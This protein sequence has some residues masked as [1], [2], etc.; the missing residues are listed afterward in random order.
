M[1]TKELR[2]DVLAKNIREETR[3]SV[4]GLRSRGIL[5]RLAAV[6]TDSN[7]AILSYAESK[8][9]MA[10]DIGITFDLVVLSPGETQDKLEAT[11]TEL[12]ADPAV[13]GIILE[14]PLASGFN[15][16]PAL[17]RIPPHKDI[18]GLTTTNLGLLYA[19]REEEALV[20]AT[21]QACVMLAEAAL[22]EEGR[23]LSGTR[24]GVVGKGR[25]VGT[26]L[27]S[28][29][30]NRHATVTVCHSKTKDLAS[31]LQDCDIVFA[32]AG[33][34]GLLDC[35]VL[36]EGQM[37]IDAGITVV[38]GKARG[39]VDMESARGFVRALTP[40]PQGVGPVTT[41][42]IFKNLLRA[43]QFQSKP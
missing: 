13:H 12:G 35:E 15:I 24:V 29:L 22:K 9:R 1:D 23:E 14:L 38:D 19:G 2:G 17:D 33:K 10:L 7:P 42:L 3:A 5:P 21:P 25:T 8:S 28:M 39:D 32:A 26:P 40:V 31:A 27:I 11:L 18:D 34:P 41:A 30:L 6:L 16:G 37:L 43:I 4:E 36:R 20:A